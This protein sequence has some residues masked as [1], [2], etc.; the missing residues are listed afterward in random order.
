MQLQKNQDFSDRAVS[1][2]IGAV[3]LISV[4]VLAVAIIGVALTSQGTPQEIPA[5]DAVISNYGSQI[6]IFHNG[7]DTLQRSEVEIWVD[8]N[9]QTFKKG[10]SDPAWAF[11][12]P[13]E[14]LVADMST[15]P[16]LVRVVYKGSSG[17]KTT[18][19]SADFSPSGMNNPGPVS[20]STL[21][22]AFSGS[23]SS[24]TPPLVVQFTDLST[25][26]P[27]G[28]N[29]AFGDG[30][31]SS[32][33]NPT[34]VFGS[35]GTYTV[36]LTVTNSTGS[37][38]SVTHPITVST[39]APSVISTSPTTG[40]R[41]TNNIPISVYG[42]GFVS[43]ATIGLKKSGSPDIAV[44]SVVFGSGTTLTGT[45]SI[46]AGSTTGA[47][48]VVV[49]NPDTQTGTLTNGF[50]VTDPAGPPTVSTPTPNSGTTGSTVFITSLP[51]TNFQ[52]GAQ[53]KL[54]SSSTADIYA[55]NI[56][57]VSPTQITC[58][59]A[60][61]GAA[62]AR[63]VVVI[64]PDGQTGMQV[65][66]FTISSVAP[67]PVTAEFSGT[68]TTG[69]IPFSVQFLDVSA[70]SPTTWSWNFGDTGTSTSQHPS[71][72]YSTAGTYSVS[73]TVGNGTGLYNTSTKT[74]YITARSKPPV[75]TGVS[76]SSGNHGYGTSSI[77]N[78]VIISGTD[79]QSG[80]TILVNNS[81]GGTIPVS[82][83]TFVS[84]TRM[85]CNL[86]LT[87][88]AAGSWN[89]VVTNPDGQAGISIGS[90]TVN[91]PAIT[92]TTL[93]PNNAR[94]STAFSM[95][96][97]GTGFEPGGPL[98][99]T[100]TRTGQT[101]RNPSTVTVVNPTMITCSISNTLFGAGQTGAWN[102]IVTN[103]DGTTSTL[104]NGF[105]VT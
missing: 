53:I 47:W 8:G 3:M 16:K 98:Q 34:H 94:R 6:Q 49:T 48:N 30:G 44:S 9:L 69:T 73:L 10:G 59:F 24:G 81:G 29:W 72:I 60:L 25:G 40:I 83:T 57:V 39:S 35:S 61:S 99:V 92:I 90:Y 5:L 43:G 84:S 89:A 82:G 15:V 79:F 27:V 55:G 14:S 22:A 68:P 103:G 91:D 67:A 74:G 42:T 88:A 50:T 51:G 70:G 75:V 2:A 32:G 86:D 102:V 52:N 58:S 21:Q 37:M 11:W 33:Q 64:N 63:N 78:P 77:F 93:Y 41:G 45:L 87:N 80:A 31:I 104:A 65:S 1:E 71:H 101:N 23:P 95:A 13:G 26:S 85:T 105:T 19:A 46:P 12:S 100:F 36:S 66:G 4:V 38:S 96:I 17:S 56:T 76:P 18:L 20:T 7:G 28:Y 54:N 97:T 62:G